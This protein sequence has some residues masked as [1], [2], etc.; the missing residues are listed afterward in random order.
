MAEI[1]RLALART[2]LVV[3]TDGSAERGLRT[4]TEEILSGIWQD[5]LHQE[6]LGPSSDFFACGGHSLLANPA[7]RAHPSGIPGRVALAGDLCHPGAGGTGSD[8]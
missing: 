1:D 4:P 3:E 5:L 8:H 7:N 6:P 2:A